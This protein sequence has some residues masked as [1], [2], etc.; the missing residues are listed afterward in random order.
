M[1]NFISIGIIIILTFLL[2]TRKDNFYNVKSDKIDSDEKYYHQ[3]MPPDNLDTLET[4]LQTIIS[5]NGPPKGANT[6]V[7]QNK[8]DL[9]FKDIIVCSCKRNTKK[10]PN[11]NNYNLMLNI[12]LD[13]IYKAELIDVYIP[14]A[15]DPS[16]NIPPFANRL[17]FT[18]RHCGGCLNGY[19][20]I[21]PGTYLSPANVACELTRQFDIVLKSALI[22]LNKY[23][24]ITVY[25]DKNLNRYIIKDR[26][27]N[28][29]SENL[30]TLIIYP[31]NGYVLDLDNVVTNSIAPVLMLTYTNSSITIPYTSG[32]KFINSNNGVL[33]V[34]VAQLGDYGTINGC[35]IPTN[36][37]DI[38]SNCIMSEVVLTNCKLYLS[39]GKLNGD[40]TIIT[41]DESGK[42]GGNVPPVFCQVP[43]NASVSSA[44]VKTLLNQ[45]SNFSAIQFYN[46]CLS[47]I[48]RLEIKWYTDDGQ[49]LRILDHCFTIRIYYFQKK[50][51]TTDFSYQII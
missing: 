17:Y 29:C 6:T 3:T 40:T 39:L 16:V 47:K 21:Q 24:G 4:L 33:F 18:Y 46:P 32:P 2:L 48:N 30:P 31:T 11:P 26:D 42:N 22:K 13:K 15:T 45:P 43:N 50:L 23:T 37:D 1:N 8:Y 35:Y 7:S 51:D 5:N 12:N 41:N 36:R 38:F 19:V 14:A 20:I 25:Y 9:V 49:L 10:Y 44:S 28:V 34:D 27:Y